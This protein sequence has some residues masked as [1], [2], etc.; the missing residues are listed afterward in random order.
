M[1]LVSLSDSR[2][3]I[4]YMTFTLASLP[5]TVV[6]AKLGV[7]TSLVLAS[8][9]YILNIL[10]LFTLESEYIILMAGVTL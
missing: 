2:S 8:I 10:Q 4:L 1:M 9:P 5:S 7:K 6:V 3:A